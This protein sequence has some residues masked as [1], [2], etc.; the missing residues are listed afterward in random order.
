[1]VLS[2]VSVRV[3]KILRI[4]DAGKLIPVRVTHFSSKASLV[5]MT[6]EGYP[7]GP[8]PATDLLDNVLNSG[9]LNP[10]AGDGK[11]LPADTAERFPG[12]GVRFSRPVI[13]RAGP[14][15]VL[16]EVHTHVSSPVAGDPFLLHALPPRA[17]GNAVNLSGQ[18]AMAPVAAQA[19]SAILA[20]SQVG[21]EQCK[22]ASKE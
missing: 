9:I 4:Y 8:R 15:I 6:P 16:F 20:V 1:M 21:A 10:D 19:V 14:D 13:N 17:G 22:P 12:L 3:G 2:S 7:L 5:A 18:N 11:A